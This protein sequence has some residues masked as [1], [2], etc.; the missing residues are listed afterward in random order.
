MRDTRNI[1][2]IISPKN[3][4]KLLDSSLDDIKNNSKSIFDTICDKDYEF[5]V[6]K[7]NKSGF[8]G[9]NRSNK[10]LRKH[11]IVRQNEDEMQKL[12][13]IEKEVGDSKELKDVVRKDE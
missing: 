11:D 5:Y 4:S 13:R 2:D 1:T 6:K 9:A 10:Q 12:E 7:V 8:G 3:H